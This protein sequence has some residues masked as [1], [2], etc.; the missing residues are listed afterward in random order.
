MADK[1][2]LADVIVLLGQRVA[3]YS[4]KIE[5]LQEACGQATTLLQYADT[6]LEEKDDEI[7]KLEEKVKRLQIGDK[8]HE[9]AR[10]LT[11][12]VKGLQAVAKDDERIKHEMVEE[13]LARENLI[14]EMRNEIHEYAYTPKGYDDAL[15]GERLARQLATD[16]LVSIANTHPTMPGVHPHSIARAA[17]KTLGVENE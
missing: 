5:E 2:T 17:L 1:K 3:S 12:K 11:A 4:A 7:A 16:A 14:V 8:H 15:N 6:W 13:S 9:Q 10:D